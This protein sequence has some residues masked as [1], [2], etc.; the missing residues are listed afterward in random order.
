MTSNPEENPEYHGLFDAT[1]AKLVP[2]SI[3]NE[4]IDK[5]ITAAL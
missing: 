2:V 3:T 4:S 1:A 5:V